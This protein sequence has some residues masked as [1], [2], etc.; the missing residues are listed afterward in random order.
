MLVSAP[1]ANLCRARVVLA[2]PCN[3][4]A[5]LQRFAI[6]QKRARCPMSE[7]LLFISAHCP[8]VR[9]IRAWRES[10]RCA[11]ASSHAVVLNG[12]RRSS[13]GNIYPEVP[14]SND[15]AASTQRKRTARAGYVSSQEIVRL[16]VKRRKEDPAPRIPFQN[17]VL[18]PSA[19]KKSD[20]HL[21]WNI[22]HNKGRN[23]PY[24]DDEDRRKPLDR[25]KVLARRSHP[26][27][28]DA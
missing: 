12:F 24:V 6:P 8:I 14:A 7:A 15:R 16:C 9:F 25:A 4:A 13:R 17:F 27:M 20:G 22:T 19:R 2:V 21:I 1:C 11:R 28:F 10:V 23:T 5:T 18:V 26:P 3:K